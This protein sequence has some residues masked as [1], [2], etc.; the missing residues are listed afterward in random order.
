[1][2]IYEAEVH[3]V[4]TMFL[5]VN[6]DGKNLPDFL[7]KLFST[8]TAPRRVDAISKVII[9]CPKNLGTGSVLGVQKNGG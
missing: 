4:S 2:P 3:T 1:M 9:K 8:Y 7:D 5:T 6:R